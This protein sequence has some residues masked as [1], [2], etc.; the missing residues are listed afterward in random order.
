MTGRGGVAGRVGGVV[1]G[2]LLDII[3][4]VC[5]LL[6]LLLAAVAAV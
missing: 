3:D 2:V 4:K 1:G 5:R 6:D